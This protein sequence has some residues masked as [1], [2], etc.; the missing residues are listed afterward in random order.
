MLRVD[1]CNVTDDIH[2]K[3]RRSSD[4]LKPSRVK[5]ADEPPPPAENYIFQ[6]PPGMGL[7]QLTV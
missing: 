1:T 2:E 5:E 3:T 6:S 7:K 4:P